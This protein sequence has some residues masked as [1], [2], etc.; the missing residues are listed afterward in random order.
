MSSVPSPI[1]TA[2][3][4]AYHDVGSA[5]AA[6]PYLA[7]AILLISIGVL[8]FNV[9]VLHQLIPKS[10]LM[11]RDIGGLI[12]NFLMTP[13]LIAI[14]RFIIL[15]EVTRRYAVNPSDRRFQLFFGWTMTVYVASC[16][17]FAVAAS[18]RSLLPAGVV[19]TGAIVICILL[20]RMT[21]LYPAVAVDAPGA[22]FAN[23]VSDTRGRAW[24]IFFLLLVPLIPMIVLTG[25]ALRLRMTLPTVTGSLLAFALVA[26][27]MVLSMA[28]LVALASRRY[29]ALAERVLQP[30][31]DGTG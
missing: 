20:L 30:P 5:F 26:T 19:M 13:V 17:L 8:L 12:S 7:V 15:G 9:L 23:A 3:W 14:H 4:K 16:I 31:A 18:S 29:L 24:Y 28:L 11:G 25:I 21:I 6:M 27:T 10:S 2:T 1:F 22:T